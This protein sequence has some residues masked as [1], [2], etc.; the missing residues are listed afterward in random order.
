MFTSLVYQVTF[1]SFMYMSIIFN[2]QVGCGMQT[3][4]IQDVLLCVHY[5]YL[6]DQSHRLPTKMPSDPSVTLCTET[7]QMLS[8]FTAAD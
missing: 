5:K 2:H 4:L 6:L 8:S 1:F 7:T 3:P